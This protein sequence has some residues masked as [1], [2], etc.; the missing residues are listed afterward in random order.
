MSNT[1]TFIVNNEEFE[2]TL[3]GSAWQTCETLSA[4]DGTIEIK[5]RSVQKPI[6]T[7]IGIINGNL[8]RKFPC[9]PF[10]VTISL[11]QINE[12]L[13]DA[14][15]TWETNSSSSDPEIIHSP[16]QYRVGDARWRME[17]CAIP[18]TRAPLYAGEA[19]ETLDAEFNLNSSDGMQDWPLE[20]SDPDRLEKFCAFYDQDTARSLILRRGK[21]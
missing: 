21:E 13:T 8:S 14:L 2:V 16:D 3:S 5:A 4:V 6:K 11:Q 19:M 18:F 10:I 15:A 20:V 9:A 17:N 1:Q 7:I 12:I